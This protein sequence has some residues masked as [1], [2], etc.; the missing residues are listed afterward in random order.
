MAVTLAKAIARGW[1]MPVFLPRAVVLI[2]A[3][4][5]KEDA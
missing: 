2:P 4:S 1:P 3:I 5:I